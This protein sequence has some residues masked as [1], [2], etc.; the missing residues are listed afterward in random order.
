MS[1]VAHDTNLYRASCNQTR[2][3][4]GNGLGFYRGIEVV[5]RQTGGALNGLRG[6]SKLVS[7]VSKAVVASGIP[8]ALVGNAAKKVPELL[9][10]GSNK[11]DIIERIVRNTTRD[12]LGPKKTNTRKRRRQQKGGNIT[13]AKSR[14][15]RGRKRATPSSTSSSPPAKRRKCTM[16]TTV[17]D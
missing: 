5:P 16:G 4:R 7:K 6:L 3:M 15:N 8:Q 17:F 13:F 2:V 10:K 9:V 14:N 12:V 11:K 1:P